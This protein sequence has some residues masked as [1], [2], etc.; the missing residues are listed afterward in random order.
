MPDC[1]RKFWVESPTDLVCTSDLLPM[2]GMTI[3]SQL[4]ALT[5]FIFLVWIILLIFRVKWNLVFL[6][7]GI[8]VI[9]IVY[10]IHYFTTKSKSVKETYT[11]R[12]GKEGKQVSSSSKMS[13]N[14]TVGLNRFS[15]A[16]PAEPLVA[17]A[18][19][20]YNRMTIT[21]PHNAFPPYHEQ[22]LGVSQRSTG[23]LGASGVPMM[24][25]DESLRWCDSNLTL[26]YDD[27]FNSSNKP[28]TGTANPKTLK[29]PIIPP[30]AM[31]WDYWMKD[32]AGR[33]SQI[34][35]TT[36]VD[37]YNSGYVPTGCDSASCNTDTCTKSGVQMV[38][39]G[40][41]ETVV[42]NPYYSETLPQSVVPGGGVTPLR[43]NFVPVNTTVPFPNQRPEPTEGQI[44]LD[45]PPEMSNA[46]LPA[47][48]YPGDVNDSMG[49]DPDLLEVG[50]PVNQ[51][52]GAC[53]RNP[54][55]S[56]YN[57]NLHTQT[58]SPGTS[59]GG[60]VYTQ[61]EVNDPIN[62]NIGISYTQ[63]FNPVVCTGDKDGTTFTSL[64]PRLPFPVEPTE[65]PCM[66]NGIVDLS[67][68][69]DP[70]FTGAGTSY[71]AYVDNMTGRVRYYYD[72]IDAHKRPNYVTRNDLDSFSWGQTTGPM[73]NSV[74]QER[75]NLRAREMA[76]QQFTDSTVSHRTELQQRM[77]QK[78]NNGAWQ[79][80]QA[81]LSRAS[82]SS[83]G[84]MRGV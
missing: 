49:Y 67:N 63:Q 66:D 42:N 31:A 78:I 4:N 44:P 73:R 45:I 19:E 54:A 79:Q 75:L 68:L 76:E 24:A 51:P 17:Q 28:L 43:E 15:P 37:F 40:R 20:N 77:M 11:V 21:Q 69:T 48:S 83:L 38:H 53:A 56:E 47:R 14:T 16:A 55:F 36:S 3:A 65:N 82:T 81:P 13:T 64:D 70:R 23:T 71:R 60:G 18:G 7:G 27:N 41:G 39:G 59:R 2:E 33:P 72:D 57:Q 26:S 80:R 34:N 50:L 52:V 9:V 62:G 35:A 8:V 29:A 10:Y 12:R 74:L 61:S 5:R 6:I 46:Y 1:N 32:N 25:T 22:P 58:I 84:G 30:P